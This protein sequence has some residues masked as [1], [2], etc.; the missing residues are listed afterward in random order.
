MRKQLCS[1]KT[2]R[3]RICG[4]AEGYPDLVRKN[5]KAYGVPQGAPLSDLLANLYLVEFDTEMHELMS[6]IG[7]YYMRYSD[8][9]LLIIPGDSTNALEQMNYVRERITD[10]GTNIKIKDSKCF[11]HRFNKIGSGLSHKLVFPEDAQRNGLS[12][13]GFRFDGRH[14]YLRDSTL[15]GLWRKISRMLA[16]DSIRLVKRY[17]GKDLEY[18]RSQFDADEII[19]RVGRVRKFEPS[20]DR[21]SWTFWTYVS[22]A[23]KV[24]GTDSRIHGQVGSYRQLIR[25]KADIKL[26]KT[27]Y[28]SLNDTDSS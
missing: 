16:R 4:E 9:I 3:E 26:S 20:L 6:R 27:Y 11:V 1:P 21:N 7:G 12:Y 28:R 19:S 25:Q 8:D 24:F 2:F 5:I 22:R 14:V 17:P 18:L 15:G 23:E 13:L 10:Y